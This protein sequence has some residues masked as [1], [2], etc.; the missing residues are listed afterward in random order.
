VLLVFLGWAGL[1]QFQDV[2][3]YHIFSGLTLGVHELGHLLFLPF[4]QVVTV[5]G[6]SVTQIAAPLLAGWLL[7]RQPDYFGVTVAG[8]WLASSLV[9]LS[10]YVADARALELPLVSIGDEPE[11]DWNFL[12][13]HFNILQ[14][15][16]RIAAWIRLAAGVI[17][18]LSLVA[19]GWLC[20]QMYRR[21]EAPA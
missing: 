7:Y 21:R 2:E 16:L 15:D 9:N 20:W 17:L 18:A 3:F 4:G 8:A 19:G 12:L 5:A 14:Y 6:G 10:I 1:R 13:D 11:H